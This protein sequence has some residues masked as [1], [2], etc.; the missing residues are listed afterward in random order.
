MGLGWPTMLDSRSHQRIPGPAY[1]GSVTAAVVRAG[2]MP[3]EL[4]WALAT[5]VGPASSARTT[6]A[7]ARVLRGINW[8]PTVG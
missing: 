4:P 5:V 3:S 2:W 8:A 6:T 1:G 7:I